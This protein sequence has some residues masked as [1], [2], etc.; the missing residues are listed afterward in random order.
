[1]VLAS[2]SMTHSITTLPAEIR[3]CDRKCRAR[4]N[5]NFRNFA[6]PWSGIDWASTIYSFTTTSP[7]KRSVCFCASCCGTRAA[8]SWCCWIIPRPTKGTPPEAP[9]PASTSLDRALPSYA[10]ELNPDQG[11]WSLAKRQLADGRPYCVDE[12]MEDVIRTMEGSEG[13]PQ[14]LRGCVLQ[15]ELPLFFVLAT[16]LFDARS[17]GNPQK[18]LAQGTDKKPQNSP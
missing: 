11:V 18:T 13:H 7:K 10:P 1:M 16:A 2:V 6:E 5:G 12:L 3:N 15:S 17:I 14:K 9:A 8:R 4:H